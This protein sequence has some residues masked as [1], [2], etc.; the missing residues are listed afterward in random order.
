MNVKNI[1][2][3]IRKKYNDFLNSIECPVLKKRLE[4]NSIFTGGAI[5]SLIQSEKPNDYDV[6]FRDKETVMQVANYFTRRFNETHK[7]NVSVVVEEDRVKCFVSSKGIAEEVEAVQEPSPFQE[8]VNN[9]ITPAL[10]ELDYRPVFI[11]SNAITLSGGIQLIIRFYGEP[12]EIH[13][14]YD[15]VHCTNYW[16]SWENKVTTNTAALEAIINKELVYVGSKYPLASMFRIRKFLNRGYH[17]NSGQ[18]L[19]IGLQINTLD[20]TSV[21]TLEDQLIGVD[22]FYFNQ[23][24]HSVAKAK[25]EGRLET[26]LQMHNYIITIVDKLF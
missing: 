24:I 17:I 20:L 1:N 15:F 2:S 6:Y 10:E 13:K 3:V 22:T 25:E 12:E 4:E 23:I 7:S 16:T 18:M 14:N 5:V 9:D 8:E 11:S 21:K 26:E 19:K